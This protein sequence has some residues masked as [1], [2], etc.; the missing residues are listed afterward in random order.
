MYVITGATGN[1]GRRIAEKL[2]AH[3]QEVTAISRTEAH[4]ADLVAKGAKA[5][6]GTLEDVEFLTKTFSGA[7]AVY[8]LIP[9]NFTA[10]DFREYQT[11]VSRALTEAVRRAGVKHAVVLSSIGA[12][13]DQSGVVA[14]LHDLEEMLKGVESL[15]VL[16]LRAGFFM[17]NFYGNIG[18]IKG[19]GI[20]GGFPIEGD[21]SMPI[22]HVN[23][24]ADVATRHLLA[25][26]FSGA[27]HVY[28]AGARDLSLKEATQVLGAAIGKP[29]LPWVTFPYEQARAGMVQ[30]GMSESLADAYVQFGKATNEGI[31]M[32][33]YQRTP[34]YT[35]P[36]D[37]E[38]FAQEFAGA[39]AQS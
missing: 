34:D 25:L 29:D 17:Q 8:L 9:P 36:T 27:S 23:D 33:D 38:A 1:T 5:A 37:I 28:V 35:T 30:V 14:G 2:L 31:L 18:L 4:L 11:T 7:T 13:S 39:Y 15:N 19:M 22:V 32:A 21:L 10:G 6:E 12:H 3:G 16:F 24:I 26:D 20:N